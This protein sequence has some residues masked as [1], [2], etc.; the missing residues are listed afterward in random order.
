MSSHHIPNATLVDVYEKSLTLPP[1]A[2]ASFSLREIPEGV[3]LI[4]IMSKLGIATGYT[5]SY[6]RNGDEIKVHCTDKEVAKG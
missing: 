5:F 2:S 3:E 1:G 4:E 6:S